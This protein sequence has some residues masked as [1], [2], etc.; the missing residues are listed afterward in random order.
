MVFPV[1]EGVDDI[2]L[3]INRDKSVRVHDDFTIGF[4][5]TT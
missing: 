3:W 5:V 1:I 4:E 2:K